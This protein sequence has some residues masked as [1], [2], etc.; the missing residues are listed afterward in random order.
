MLTNSHAPPSRSELRQAIVPF[1]GDS[2]LG[3][4]GF[5]FVLRTVSFNVSTVVQDM[6][7]DL[8]RFVLNGRCKRGE[9]TRDYGYTT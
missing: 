5:C 4:D 7:S 6:F 3:R 1:V 9:F 2:I 8:T